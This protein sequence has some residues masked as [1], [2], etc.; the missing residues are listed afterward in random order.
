[1]TGHRT[2]THDPPAGYLITFTTYGER[3]HGD[4]RGSVER[5]RRGGGAQSLEPDPTRE[6]R[7]R[8]NVRSAAPLR[9]DGKARAVVAATITEVARFKGWQLH[10][11]NVR[12]N[13]VHVVVSGGEAP[14][15]MMNAFKAWATRRL[16]EAGLFPES[17]EIW[18]RHGSTRYLWAERDIE[19][20][21][22][23]VAEA[24]GEDIGGVRWQDGG[25]P[26]GRI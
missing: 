9:L 22:L 15:R 1:V 13:H 17:E 19:Q 8:R 4:P 20:A 16:R 21:C 12:T 26:D 3:L 11:V 14:E 7:E 18:T 24:Q 10:T 5:I 23:C 25:L 6:R 2:P